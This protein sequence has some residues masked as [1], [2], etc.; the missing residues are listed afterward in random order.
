MI[1]TVNTND[2]YM[3]ENLEWNIVYENKYWYYLLNKP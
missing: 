2:N 3:S 1:D